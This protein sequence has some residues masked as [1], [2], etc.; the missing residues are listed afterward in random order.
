MVDATSPRIA[1]VIV[2]C[3]GLAGAAVTAVLLRR[4][5]RG[6]ALSLVWTMLPPI[7]AA[8]QFVDSTDALVDLRY[9]RAVITAR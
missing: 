6:T 8:D 4:T 9:P 3:G 5:G 1:F 7:G 2:G